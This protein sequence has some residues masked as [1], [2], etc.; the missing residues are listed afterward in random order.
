[1]TAVAFGLSVAA[2]VGCHSDGSYKLTWSF[3]GGEAASALTCAGHGVFSISVVGSSEGGDSE[4]IEAPCASG[5]LTDGVPSGTWSFTVKALDMAGRYRGDVLSAVGPTGATADAGLADAAADGGAPADAATDGVD[6]AD[7]GSDAV[8]PADAIADGV[9]PAD[10]ADIPAG[11]SFLSAMVGPQSIDKGATAV[12]AVVLTPL[13]A[14]ADGID[15]DCDGRVD[16]DDPSCQGDPRGNEGATASC[17]QQPA[18][19]P[20]AP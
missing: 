12:F 17:N 14:C 13:P 6:P 9:G 4:Q 5:A 18:G 19:G 20:A 1:M 10:A 16:L 15:N 11:A 3:A 8:I 2:G 7:A